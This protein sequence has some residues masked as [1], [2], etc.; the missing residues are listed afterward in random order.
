MYCSLDTNCQVG[1]KPGLATLVMAVSVGLFIQNWDRG[2]DLLTLGLELVG[3]SPPETM[4]APPP[5]TRGKLLTELL[6]PI[7]L[8]C[9]SPLLSHGVVLYTR[10]CFV[11]VSSHMLNCAAQHMHVL[12][13]MNRTCSYW[14]RQGDIVTRLGLC[15]SWQR[16]QIGC[17]A[18]DAML[19][20]SCG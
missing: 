14:M 18:R 13:Q 20:R 2:V 19:W 9:V 6:C 4:T 16:V 12:R 15:Y 8:S 3:L 10:V 17:A 1:G 11:Y 7:L 5:P